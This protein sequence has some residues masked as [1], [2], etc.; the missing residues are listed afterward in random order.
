MNCWFSEEGAAA[1]YTY[2]ADDHQETGGA[3]VNFE[4]VLHSIHC[5]PETSREPLSPLFWPAYNAVKAYREQVPMPPSEQSLLVK[6]ENNLRSALEKHAA[7]LEEYLPFMRTL[8]HDLKN[9][10]PYQSILYAG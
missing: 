2:C 10:R 6:T 3:P 9:I 7:D 8:L 5:R 4:S 1:F